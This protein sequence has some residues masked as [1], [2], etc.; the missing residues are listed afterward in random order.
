MID[1]SIRGGA[2]AGQNFGTASRLMVK[3]SIPDYTWETY[4]CFDLSG[5]KGRV[6]EARVRLVPVRV[7]QPFT[8]AVAPVLDNHWGETTLTWD[9]KPPSG[10]P[11]ASW[12]VIEREPVEIDVTRLVQE[13]LAGDRKL[14]LRI[15]APEFKRQKYFVEYGSRKGEAETRPQLLVSTVPS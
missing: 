9:Q 2:Y 15:F 10:P 1:A 13:A 7:G 6:T 4:L 3:N 12:T 14:S 8:N 5:I 11:F